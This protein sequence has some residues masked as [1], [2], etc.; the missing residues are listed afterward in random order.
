MEA[1]AIPPSPAVSSA[2]VDVGDR[3]GDGILYGLT[4]LAA[5]VGVVIVVAIIWR[6]ADGAWPAIERLRSQLHLAQRPGTRR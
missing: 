3:L 6:V 4:A 2:R 5:L 1:A